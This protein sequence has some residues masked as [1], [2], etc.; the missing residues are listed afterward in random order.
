MSDSTRR[1]TP[2]VLIVTLFF[3]A[4]RAGGGEP[5]RVDEFVFPLDAQHNHAPGIV[6]CPNGDLLVSWYRGSGERKADDVAVYGARKLRG[7]SS[8]SEPFLMADTPGFP[9]CN[10]CMMIDPQDRLWL[11]W[12]VII[13]NSWESCLTHYKIADADSKQASVAPSWSEQ[14]VILLKPDDFSVEARRVLDSMVEQTEA[15]RLQPY[16][17]EIAQLR[18]PQRSA[19]PATRLATTLQANAASLRAHPAAPV[20]GYV[21]HFHHG[22]E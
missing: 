8:W 2:I 12:P 15:E 19:L 17:Q 9:D 16:E 5:M 14:G 4:A 7:S 20:Y 18:E 6:E 11:F 13:A 22:G 21:F 10:T 3:L 1:L